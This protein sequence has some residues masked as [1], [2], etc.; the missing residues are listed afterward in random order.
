MVA[1]RR[2]SLQPPPPV[3]APKKSVTVPKRPV[4]KTKTYGKARFVSRTKTSAEKRNEK[5]AKFIRELQKAHPNV[6]KTEVI[7][8]V[9]EYQ[10]VK[11]MLQKIFT[12]AGKMTCPDGTQNC[13]I[14]KKRKGPYL[15]SEG[16]V[17]KL[18]T[19]IKATPYDGATRGK[20]ALSMVKKRVEADEQRRKLIAQV[21]DAKLTLSALTRGSKQPFSRKITEMNVEKRK[22]RVNRAKAAAKTKRAEQRKT[23]AAKTKQMNDLL[24]DNF[25]PDDFNEPWKMMGLKG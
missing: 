14:Q 21:A 25:H 3:A 6:S 8:R 7:Y 18:A 4:V 9:R 24:N 22:K 20:R 10:T 1:T 11:K 23:S 15:V 12:G 5:E 2:G 19:I 17:Q 13:S 16:T